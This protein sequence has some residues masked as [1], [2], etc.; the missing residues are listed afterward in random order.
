MKKWLVRLAQK[1]QE[2]MLATKSNISSRT[3]ASIIIIITKIIIIIITVI[4]IIIIIIVIIKLITAT[5]S[6]SVTKI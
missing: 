6:K 2:S 3:I 4:I 1:Q 5:K